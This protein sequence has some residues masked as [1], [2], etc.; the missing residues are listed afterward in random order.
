MADVDRQLVRT[1]LQQ[2]FGLHVATVGEC[3]ERHGRCT[4]GMIL[5]YSK[6]R[7]SQIKNA[8]KVLLQLDLVKYTE[9]VDQKSL[10]STFHYSLVDIDQI[11]RLM[12]FGEYCKFITESVC[13]HNSGN[14][15]NSNSDVL[16]VFKCLFRYGRQTVDGIASL[17]GVVRTAVEQSLMILSQ[18]QEYRVVK[19]SQSSDLQ[20]INDLARQHAESLKTSDDYLK[21]GSSRKRGLN[22][23][24]T[25]GYGQESGK[26][27]LVQSLHEGIQFKRVVLSQTQFIRDLDKKNSGDSSGQDYYV[28]DFDRLNVLMRN[29]DLSQ[30]AQKIHPFASSVMSTILDLSTRNMDH[31]L[32]SQDVETVNLMKVAQVIQ[33]DPKSPIHSIPSNDRARVIR[34]HL[35][36]LSNPDSGLV[37]FIRPMDNSNFIV[38]FPLVLAQC[39]REIV[40]DYVLVRHGGM[41]LRVYRAVKQHQIL[42][43]KTLSKYCF[44]DIAECRNNIFK[45]LNDQ[46]IQWQLVPRSSDRAPNRALYA[47]KANSQFQGIITTRIKQS[48]L[49]MI[50]K[51]GDL[52]SREEYKSLVDK[53]KRLTAQTVQSKSMMLTKVE[54]DKLK[55]YNTALQRLHASIVQMDKTLRIMTIY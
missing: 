31:P 27:R 30:L 20:H 29:R 5:R 44:L 35:N 6:M 2:F 25:L 32:M 3:L 10:V 48:I 15:G 47:L 1:V 36:A 45:L 42:D 52:T 4:I 49:N 54:Q 16:S 8:L 14:S 51:I 17:S 46:V 55:T 22:D 7:V 13:R 43:E 53:Q 33:N 37:Q 23:A 9:E 11:L 28:I 21:V 34:S 18:Q 38:N 12:R 24:D 40:E 39:Q 26:R 19:I 50:I 41:A